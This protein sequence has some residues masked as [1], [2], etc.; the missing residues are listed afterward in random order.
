[1]FIL[2]ELINYFDIESCEVLVEVLI[3]YIG[4]VILVS[5]DMYLLSLV[6]DC[7]WL[8]KDGVV[9]FYEDD[10]DVYCWLLL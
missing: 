8:V 1:M 4:V 3:V 10:L 9:K 2:D 5:Y 7:L 6:V